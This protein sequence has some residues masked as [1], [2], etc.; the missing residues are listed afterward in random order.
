MPEQSGTPPR[1]TV[2]PV[3]FIV[4][5]VMAPLSIAALGFWALLVPVF[6]VYF[7]AIPYLLFGAP[8]F[9]LSLHRHGLHADKLISIGV[10][11]NGFIPFAF[12]PVALFQGFDLQSY[13]IASDLLLGFGALIGPL[14]A[15]AFAW[16]YKFLRRDA[17][18]TVH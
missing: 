9:Y 4:A 11:A 15:W 12:I 1:H 16:I 5:L 18:S 17:F 13:L 6:A 3:A 2:D 14:W 10:Y 8:L 7:G